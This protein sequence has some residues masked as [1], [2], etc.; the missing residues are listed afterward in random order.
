MAPQPCAAHPTPRPKALSLSRSLILPSP[1]YFPRRP[2]SL[3]M[4]SR[5]RTCNKS[6]LDKRSLAGD[7]ETRRKSTSG[8][9]LTH[10]W[11]GCHDVC[12]QGP[13][14]QHIMRIQAPHDRL[15]TRLAPLT[16]ALRWSRRLDTG[17]C[18]P[19]RQIWEH[20]AAVAISVEL[21]R[22]EAASFS[23]RCNTG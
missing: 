6:V 21:V 4:L 16:E 15:H 9:W 3:T 2:A 14:F 18:I 22:L 13:T 8:A 12:S 20:G 10:G 17:S 1:T 7:A 5:P 11:T 19:N 23:N